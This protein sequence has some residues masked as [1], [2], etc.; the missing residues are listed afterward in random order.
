MVCNMQ[1]SVVAVSKFGLSPN[2]CLKTQNGSDRTK[3]RFRVRRVPIPFLFGF[4]KATSKCDGIK[5]ICTSNLERNPACG[6]LGTLK[7]FDSFITHKCGASPNFLQTNGGLGRNWALR[8]GVGEDLPDDYQ[9]DD[10][11]KRFPQRRCGILFHPTS[12]PGAYGI[13]ELGKEA[14][15]FLDWLKSTG[16]TVWQV[17]PLVPPGRKGGEDGSPYAGSDANCGNTSL[18]S[19]D[20]LVKEGLLE[21][22]DLPNTVPVKKIDYAAVAA[23]KDP[24]VAK[25]AKKLLECS[26]TAELRD[27]FERFRNCPRI[28]AWLEDAALFAAIEQSI[29]DA[30][31]WRNWPIP[32]RDRDPAALDAARHK[33]KDF[34]TNFIGVQF[35]FQRQ[36]HAVHKYANEAGIKVLGDMPMYVGAH[37]ADVWAHR[38][39]F[40][41][42]PETG[43]PSMVSGVPPD[44]FSPTG[45]LW[46]SPL[47][48]WKEMAKD[49]YSWWTTRLR[50]ASQLYDEFRIDHFRGFAGYWAIP[51]SASSAKSG[52]WRAGPGLAFFTVVQEALGKLDIIAEDLGVITGD[53]VALRKALNAPGMAVL[54]F[55][56]GDDSRNPHLPHNHEFEQVVY[57]GTHDNE[58]C[59]GWW[60]NASVKER[61]ITKSYF[62]F[63]NEDDVHWEFIRGAIASNARTAIISMQDVMGLDNSA[64]MNTPATQVGNWGWRIGETCAFQK[65]DKEKARLR[66]L[67]LSFNRLPRVSDVIVKK[68]APC[69]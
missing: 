35:L 28:C 60:K 51:A 18:I 14:F 67:L 30:K 63:H 41:L 45:Q 16:C 34:I 69:T 38:S 50:R 36:W 55:G 61:D 58:T 3:A 15:F 32:L 48:N 4:R 44:A 21:K 7:A 43:A 54:Q 64:R 49:G 23:T 33:H 37:S 53:V 47:Y 24:L 39:L 6:S 13:G 26:C 31:F 2:N 27:D 59:V 52:K 10:P 56:F 1:A 22:A 5:T 20:E 11:L 19:L 65:L 40:M 42:D 12:L 46:G 25:A 8:V 62:R 57:P 66:E 29:L 68:D 17:L 9:D